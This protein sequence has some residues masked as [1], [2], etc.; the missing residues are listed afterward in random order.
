M[1][2]FLAC[3]AR[4]LTIVLLCF[5]G[6]AAHALNITVDNYGWPGATTTMVKTRLLETETTATHHD[7]WI[8]QGGINNLNYSNGNVS[9]SKAQL[10]Q[11]WLQIR[12]LARK[13]GVDAYYCE[14]TPIASAEVD[15][16]TA[17]A[18]VN[19]KIQSMNLHIATLKIDY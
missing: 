8:I 7:I 18:P 6:L 1:T 13:W 11:D 2:R 15:P 16:V 10:S 9:N 17:W 19:P 14:L 12:D 3:F 4:M 5:S